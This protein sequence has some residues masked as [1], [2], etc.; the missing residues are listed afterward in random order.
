MHIFMIRHAE[1]EKNRAKVL[2]GRSNAP[3][4]EAGE[5]QSRKA[6]RYFV[7][8]G[9]CFDRI[10][11]SPLVRCI[12]TAKIIAQGRE[13]LIVTDDRLLEM[14]YGPYEGMSLES[15][16]PEIVHFFSDF[17]HNPAPEGM[18][19]LEGVKERLKDFL[20]SVRDD[21]YEN[22]LI[23]T[24]AIALKGALESLTPDSGGSYWSRMIGNCAVFE[25]E[26][27]DGRFSVPEE[28]FTLG[29]EPGV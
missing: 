11:S 19:S 16:P 7:E 25:S 12:Q 22:V 5:E 8:R 10:Y 6:G 29:Y 21:Q 4:N 13:D 26:V 2:Q 9:I 20:V 23:A 18:E 3:L 27:K 24:H 28:V 15:P 17:V 14:D 1:T